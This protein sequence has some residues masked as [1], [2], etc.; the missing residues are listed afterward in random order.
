MEASSKLALSLR[1]EEVN[2]LAAADL[3]GA[4]AN[5]SKADTAILI[6]TPW[7][8]CRP[9]RVVALDEARTVIE[10][11]PIPFTNS[12]TGAPIPDGGVA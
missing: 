3:I 2:P 7:G 5:G 12:V 4:I 9:V 8:W 1:G 6:E 11:Q 10:T